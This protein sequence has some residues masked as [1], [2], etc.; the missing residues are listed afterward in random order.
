MA[1]FADA[2][3]AADARCF[4]PGCGSAH[5]VAYLARAGRPWTA[6][7]EFPASLHGE[8]VV[9]AKHCPTL[10]F[11]AEGLGIG[12][13]THPIESECLAVS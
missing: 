11:S 10:P 13:G 2:H 6:G 4:V 12:S 7:R 8:A 5:D 1:E 3:V 9:S